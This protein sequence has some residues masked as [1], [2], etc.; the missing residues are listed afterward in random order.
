[1]VLQD[2]LGEGHFEHVRHVCGT[3]EIG[4]D[5][6]QLAIGFLACRS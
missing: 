6:D 3:A 5:L 4:E 2:C 1:M